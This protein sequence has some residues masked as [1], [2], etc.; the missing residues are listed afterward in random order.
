M[1]PVETEG[2]D[3]DTKAVFFLRFRMRDLSASEK[4]EHVKLQK[5]MEK[6]NVELDALRSQKEKLQEEVKAGEKTIDE[7]KEQ[8]SWRRGHLQTERLT[9]TCVD[10]RS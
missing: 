8:V 4:Q 9:T 3:L 1:Y 5:Q 10:F 6:K 7:L 2:V